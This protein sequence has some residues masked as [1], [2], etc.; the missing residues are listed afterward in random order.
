MTNEQIFSSEVFSV[1][2]KIVIVT[3]GSRGIGAMMARAFV[4][5]GA[6][7][8]ITS[9][10]AEACDAMADQLSAYGSCKSLP[11]DLSTLDGIK[12]FTAAFFALEGKVDVL[13]N[14]AGASWG[15]PV[16]EFSEAGWDKIVDINMKSP[17]FTVQHLLPA[18]AASATKDSPSKVINISS[19]Y[20]LINSSLDNFSYTASKA[21]L[22]HLTRHLA[23]KLSD[24]RINVNAIAPGHF[25]TKM[26]ELID[27]DDTDEILRKIPL[28]RSGNSLDI[29]GAA[30]FLASQASDYMTGATMVVDGGLVVAV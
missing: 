26:T 12:E 14:N 25:E 20:G 3:G 10:K 9:R 15:E 11:A 23:L 24:R 5:G 27:S 8:Y 29:S 18:L 16:G 19:A 4:Q 13:V 7:T 1:A 30:V 2:N 6:K 21:G 22:E 17:F 28:G